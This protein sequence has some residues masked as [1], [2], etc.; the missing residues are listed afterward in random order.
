MAHKIL[1]SDK[2]FFEYK[3]E[4]IKKMEEEISTLSKD[5]FNSTIDSLSMIFSREYGY[6]KIQLYE[7]EKI[8]GGEVQKS[9][10]R[11]SRK[12]RFPPKIN[13]SNKKT[14]N[15]LEIRLPF[16][17]E[18]E[19]FKVMPSKF[20]FNPPK[21]DRLEQNHVIY[22]IDFLPQ[23]TNSDEI[24]QKI[25]NWRKDVEKW[26]KNLNSNIEELNDTLEKKAKSALKA[27]KERLQ[28]RDEIFDDLGVFT[29]KP[30][31]N[32]FVKPERKRKIH[33]EPSIDDELPK[34]PHD[35]FKEI[36]DIIDDI[37][38]DLE[39]S[40][41][42]IRE[43]DEKPIRDIIITALNSHFKGFVTGESYNKGGKT[44]ILLRYNHENLFVAECKFWHGISKYL[45]AID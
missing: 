41:K 31:S 33:F 28:N 44:D 34:L 32:G 18:K 45:E 4:R 19:L 38:R 42:K 8:D 26:V 3:K 17:G 12:R 35:T 13:G 20:N 1:F 22:F 14:V 29:Q 7:I 24:G 5:D 25:E 39:R 11:K 37:G 40:S 6:S 36:L 9:I 2:K 16:E 43:L 10:D 30:G 27:R 21:Y 15:R 23:S